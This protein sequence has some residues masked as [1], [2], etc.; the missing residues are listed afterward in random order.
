MSAKVRRL[1]EV[2]AH[3]RADR[4]GRGGGI[5]DLDILVVD[6]D[7]PDMRK[8][9]GHDLRGVGRIGEDLLVAGHCGV[10]ADLA[11][12]RADRADAEAF[13]HLAIGQHENACGD[14][15]PPARACLRIVC[16]A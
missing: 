14:A 1:R 10:E 2:G 7:D 6:A 3:D 15:R 9:E 16:C 11:D 8:G 4:G 5:D 12:R 13:D